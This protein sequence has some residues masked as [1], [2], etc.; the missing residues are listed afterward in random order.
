MNRDTGE[1]L[2]PDPAD[3]TKVCPHVQADNGNGTCGHLWHL[4]EKHSVEWAHILKSG[5][6]KTTSTMIKEAFAA[7][8]DKTKSALNDDDE[9][10]LNRLVARW[11]AKCGRPQ[12]IVEDEELKELLAAILEL[13]KSKYRYE[14]PCRGTVKRDLWLLGEDGKAVGRDFIK[15]LIISGVKV[16]ITGDL[17]SDNGMGLFGIY[18]H[19]IT[20]TWVIE[21]KL[22]GLVACESQRHTAENITTWTN[23]ALKSIGMDASVLLAA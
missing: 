12:A 22:I 5:E 8:V 7:K 23:D 2:L 10:M 3:R 11:V 18:A 16:S 21:K 15:R 19:G 14:L 1:C 17:W 6:V 13:C 9:T 20:E 4:R